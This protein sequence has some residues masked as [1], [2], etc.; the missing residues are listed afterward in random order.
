MHL[1]KTALAIILLVVAHAAAQQQP[2]PGIWY[3]IS[4]SA[5]GASTDERF[6]IQ[7]TAT[8]VVILSAALGKT[9]SSWGPITLR[10]DGSIQ[11]Q[12]AD[13]P[14]LRCTL[15]RIDQRNYKGTC[16]R[17]GQSERQLTLT[18]E[19]PPRGLEL[20][21]ADT[22]FRILAKARHILSGTSVWNRHDDRACEDDAK[23]NSWS[24]FCALYQASVDTVG[25][26]LHLRP[27]M[28]EVRAVVGEATNRRSFEHQLRDFNNLDSITYADIASIF[29][30]TQKRL[31]ARKA[32]AEKRDSMTS[33]EKE[34]DLPISSQAIAPGGEDLIYWSE[35]LA[36]TVQNK[37]YRLV[38]TLGPIS[39]SGKLPDDWLAAST[40]ATRRT[41]KHR[42]TENVDVKG[43]LA[44]GN[45]W[46]YFSQ[47]GE[48]LKYY[49]VPTEASA[50][51]DRIIDGAY[52][53]NRQR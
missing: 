32:C 13:N 22:D 40:A 25:V 36:H 37:T 47:C 51:F 11:F 10:Q 33:V 28:M 35:G 53:L 48:S 9:P 4:P 43:K 42:D 45:H 12:W 29:D 1:V 31:Q 24:L 39:A 7:N 50:F 17:S 14:R 34:Y 46:R 18:R 8:G 26:Y 19:G 3:G 2:E 15:R 44:N 49:D 30:G 23:R 52:V 27:A 5:R 6:E 41:W 20:H 38:V 21:V 16:W